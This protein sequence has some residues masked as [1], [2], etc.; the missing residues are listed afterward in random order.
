MV[1]SAVKLRSSEPVRVRT[2]K[3]PGCKPPEINTYKI[4]RLK[5]Y[6]NEHL[7]KMGRGWGARRWPPTKRILQV[8]CI[9]KRVLQRRLQPCGAMVLSQ[10]SS[11]FEQGIVVD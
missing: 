6:E 1:V 10:R 9:Q 11:W 4:V 2:Y 3:N 8:G 5:L 7:Q